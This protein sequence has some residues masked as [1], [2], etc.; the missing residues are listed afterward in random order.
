MHFQRDETYTARCG[1]LLAFSMVS[2]PLSRSALSPAPR[3][4]E[5]HGS[6]GAVLFANLKSIM[7]WCV[8][9]MSLNV[10]PLFLVVR[11]YQRIAEPDRYR[12]SRAGVCTIDA[13]V[14]CLAR[15]AAYAGAHDARWGIKASASM[16]HGM[17]AAA[18]S[19]MAWSLR[20]P[21]PSGRLEVEWV[22]RV[23]GEFRLVSSGRVR[24]SLEDRDVLRLPLLWPSS[25][26]G[27]PGEV[28]NG[29]W[30]EF[31]IRAP[32]E[33]RLA[34]RRRTRARED[35]ALVEWADGIASLLS[36]NGVHADADPTSAS[37]PS[38]R[39]ELI[40]APESEVMSDVQLETPWRATLIERRPAVDAPSWWACWKRLRTWI[41]DI[42]I[43]S[44]PILLGFGGTIILLSVVASVEGPGYALLPLLGVLLFLPYVYFTLNPR[45]RRVRLA[46]RSRELVVVDDVL[47][48]TAG[49]QVDLGVPF[50]V[51]LT[52]EADERAARLGVEIRPRDGSRGERIRFSVPVARATEAVASLPR[53]ESRAPIVDGGPFHETLW[54][55]LR[56]RAAAHGDELPWRTRRVDPR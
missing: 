32:L 45:F 48:D 34:D 1:D 50:I 30:I 16:R 55:L 15:V 31:E 38:T 10:A 54:P 39:V 56:S 12:L 20:T 36:V 9:W 40:P 5:R 14:Q 51:D 25:F 2:A 46:A 22:D 44:L 33:E 3:W 28:A 13:A 43:G 37:E 6:V 23:D 11:L 41:Q 29:E 42:A 8:S 4:P 7:A 19:R 52:R 26:G 35:D 24:L 21:L 18:P 53:L 17:D 27:R 49:A 47:S